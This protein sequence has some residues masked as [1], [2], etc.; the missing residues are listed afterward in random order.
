MLSNITDA[1]LVCPLGS[2]GAVDEVFCRVANT[3]VASDRPPA[4]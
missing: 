4:A 3:R 2:C 1:D